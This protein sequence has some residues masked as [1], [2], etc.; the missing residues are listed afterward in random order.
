LV[1]AFFVVVVVTVM[2]DL[3]NGFID[4]NA[5]AIQDMDDGLLG[6]GDLDG[7][8]STAVGAANGSSACRKGDGG[9]EVAGTVRVD[10][11]AFRLE[12]K[13]VAVLYALGDTRPLAYR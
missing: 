10:G 3:L 6:D 11:N 4:D 8:G 2:V 5:A 13:G 9:V 1:P 7:G 12:C